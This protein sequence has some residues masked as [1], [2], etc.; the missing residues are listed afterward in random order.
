MEL[1]GGEGDTQLALMLAES[2]Y[3]ALFLLETTILINSM[4]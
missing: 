1:T 3:Q 4:S 2:H